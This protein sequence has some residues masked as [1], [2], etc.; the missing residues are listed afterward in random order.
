MYLSST[1]PSTFTSTIV[2]QSPIA[3]HGTIGTVGFYAATVF[4]LFTP[5]EPYETAMLAVG[6]GQCLYWGMSGNPTGLTAVT[7]H[8]G[9]GSRCTPTLDA[10]TDLSTNTTDHLVAD[11]ESLARAPGRR[12]LGAA[13]CG[14]KIFA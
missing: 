11:L 2:A 12:A 13:R 9:P 3:S 4:G 14:A 5:I 6:A 1:H 8:G 10:N 7:L